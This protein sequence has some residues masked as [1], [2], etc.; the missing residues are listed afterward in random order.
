MPSLGR[1]VLYPTGMLFSKVTI[2]RYIAFRRCD[3]VLRLFFS[4]AASPWERD[5]HGC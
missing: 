5:P 1:T 2:E 4:G 3:N